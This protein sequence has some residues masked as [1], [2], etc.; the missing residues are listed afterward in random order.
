MA[1]GAT[2]GSHLHL[3]G[4]PGR[5]AMYNGR[6]P[7]TGQSP[8]SVTYFL[9]PGHTGPSVLLKQLRQLGSKHSNIYVYGSHSCCNHR[10]VPLFG[11]YFA[12]KDPCISVLEFLLLLQALPYTEKYFQVLLEKCYTW[13]H[14]TN[15]HMMCLCGGRRHLASDTELGLMRR[16]SPLICHCPHRYL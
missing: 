13:S 16:Y 14:G 15:V 2:E 4:R 11:F 10:I 3:Q 8:P 6:S 5:E 12:L 1:A 7:L 9:Q